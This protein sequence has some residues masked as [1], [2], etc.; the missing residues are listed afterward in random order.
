MGVVPRLPACRCQTYVTGSRV[1]PLVEWEKCLMCVSGRLKCGLIRWTA[2]VCQYMDLRAYNTTVPNPVG[3]IE[4]PKIPFTSR[5]SLNVILRKA[6]EGVT[7]SDYNVTLAM[8]FREE[9]KGFYK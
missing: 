7:S 5:S 6:S 9:T 4:K 1:F 2:Y 8:G 3:F